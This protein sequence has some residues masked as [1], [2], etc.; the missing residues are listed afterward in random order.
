L[1]KRLAKRTTQAWTVFGLSPWR[2]VSSIMGCR[3]EVIESWCRKAA[4]LNYTE[5]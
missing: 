3:T 2:V 1:P 5:I 4:S